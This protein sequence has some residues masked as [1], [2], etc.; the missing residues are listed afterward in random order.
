MARVICGGVSCI[1]W[2]AGGMDSTCFV[3]EVGDV[4]VWLS[5]LGFRQLLCLMGSKGCLWCWGSL[6][7]MWW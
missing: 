4:G 6:L 5:C 2:H 1:T 3:V 7:V